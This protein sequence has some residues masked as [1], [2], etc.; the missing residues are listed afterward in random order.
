MA[1]GPGGREPAASPAGLN[2]CSPPEGKLCGG[3]SVRERVRLASLPRFCR[4]K[5]RR[6][7]VAGRGGRGGARSGCRSELGVCRGPQFTKPDV[8]V[9]F[10]DPRSNGRGAASPRGSYL[11]SSST[12]EAVLG[13]ELRGAFWEK[14]SCSGCAALARNHWGGRAGKNCACRP[15]LIQLG[16][17]PLRGL[18]PPA[19]GAAAFGDRASGALNK[20]TRTGT[21][22][23]YAIFPARRLTKHS[24]VDSK[25][26]PGSNRGK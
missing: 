18:Y 14:L 23:H 8:G 5:K 25:R 11:I 20:T 13:K 15:R 7:S 9:I 22:R 12:F 6:R 10:A 19:G 17:S 2:S 21:R 1:P 16:F 3:A 24:K 4:K 26:S